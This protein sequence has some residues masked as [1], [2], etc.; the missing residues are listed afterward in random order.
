MHHGLSINQE[1]L[2]STSK[3]KTEDI[4]IEASIS[5]DNTFSYSVQIND[6]PLL[7]V[8]NLNYK[9]VAKVPHDIITLMFFKI[10][11]DQKMSLI[12]TLNDNSDRQTPDIVYE[13]EPY[14]W[15]VLEVKTTRRSDQ[16]NQRFYSA[17][18]IYKPAC[19]KRIKDK[20]I[21]LNALIIS[22]DQVCTNLP[23]SQ[24]EAD[25]LSTIYSLGNTIVNKFRGLGWS[26]QE[27]DLKFAVSDLKSSVSLLTIP[28]SSEDDLIIT[29]DKIKMWRNCDTTKAQIMM[30]QEFLK[31]YK[32]ASLDSDKNNFNNGLKLFEDLKE[33]LK[34]GRKDNKSVVQLPLFI[35]YDKFCEENS[36]L[37]HSLMFENDLMARLW[38]SS[39]IDRANNPERILEVSEDD[40]EKYAL[41]KEFEISK[42][43]KRT[44]FRV[45]VSLFES[46]WEELALH[47]IE[48]KK[49]KNNDDV[50]HKRAKDKEPFSIDCDVFDINSFIK[51]KSNFELQQC[52]NILTDRTIGLIEGAANSTCPLSIEFANHF[53]NTK[54]GLALSQMQFI[55]TEVNISRLQ[56][57]K[58]HQFV[59][60]YIKEINVYILIKPSRASEHIFFSLAI[61]PNSYKFG[62]PFKDFKTYGG[63][64]ISD[65]VSMDSN[66]LSHQIGTPERAC[67]LLA[68]W[69]H[70]FEMMPYHFWTTEN[71]DI[72]EHF[73]ASL[74]FYMED[75]ESTSTSLQNIRYAYMEMIKGPGRFLNPLKVLKKMSDRPKSRLLIW[76]MSRFCTTFLDMLQSPPSFGIKST[77]ELAEEVS[78]D[79]AH[80][81]LSWV[82]LRPIPKFEIALN[83]SY[84]GVLHNKEEGDKVTGF[85]KIFEKVIGEELQLRKSNLKFCG[86]E[87]PMPDHDY[88]SH[89]FSMS[90]VANMGR[91]CKEY[92]S[93][94]GDGSIQWVYD[95]VYEDLAKKDFLELATM[96]AS[97]Y[98]IDNDVI[99]SDKV[100]LN[101]RRRTAEAV[102][103]LLTEGF[104]ANVMLKIHEIEQKV[105]DKGGLQ[106]NLFKKMQ[107]GGT[108][109]I[110]VL[111][112]ES[113]ILV[114]F[115][116]SVC[117]SV[118]EELP[119]EM[120]TKGDQKILRNDAHFKS[121]NSLEG[122]YSTTVSSSDDATTWAQKFVMNAFA[123]YLCNIFD[124]DLMIPLACVLNHCTNKRLELPKELLDLFSTHPEIDSFSEN[125]N[126]LKNQFLGKSHYNDLL[127]RYM[128]SLKNRSNM[129]QGIFHYTS[130]LYHS[131]FLLTWSEFSSK[132][133]N[134]V[135]KNIHSNQ[136]SFVISTKVSSDDS[137][138]LISTRFN[139]YKHREKINRL[140]LSLTMLKGRLYKYF[141]CKQSEEKSTVGVFWTIEEF[142]SVWLMRNTILMPLIKFVVSSTQIHT[143]PKIETRMFIAS[144]LRS[145]ILENCGSILLSAIV[146]VCQARLHYVGLGA[147][148]NGLWRKYSAI[149]SSKPH[150]SAGYFVME[151]EMMC[152]LLGMDL[153]VYRTCRFNEKFKRIHTKLVRNMGVEFADEGNPASRIFLSHGHNQRY[154][155]FVKT[156]GLKSNTN[157][158]EEISNQVDILYRSPVNNSEAQLKLLVKCSDPE[159][160]QAFSFLNAAKTFCSSVYIIQEHCIHLVKSVRATGEIEHERISLLKWLDL[161]EED[162][163]NS[164]EDVMKIAFPS[165]QF[166]DS[167]LESLKLVDI[168]HLFSVQRKRRVF[169]SVA[170][171]K[172]STLTPMTLLDCMRRLWFGISVRGSEAALEATFQYYKEVYP[173]L[174]ADYN[175]TFNNSPFNSH[176]ALSK[177]ITSLNPRTKT[178]RVTTPSRSKSNTFETLFTMILLNQWPKHEIVQKGKMEGTTVN[179]VLDQMLYSVWLAKN[180]PPLKD[181]TY[182][183]NKIC[184]SFEDVVTNEPDI[185]QLMTQGMS[186]FNIMMLQSACLQPTM[187]LKLLQKYNKGIFGGF[188][189]RQI[190]D[191]EK[192]RYVGP[193]LFC[194]SIDSIKFSLEII[195]G[196]IVC[197]RTDNKPKIIEKIINLSHFVQDLGLCFNSNYGPSLNYLRITDQREGYWSKGSVLFLESEMIHYFE[198][199]TV[200]F[201]CDF[202]GRIRIKTVE[203]RPI[204]VLSFIPIVKHIQPV[205]EKEYH[206]DNEYIKVWMRNEKLSVDDALYLLNRSEEN[207]EFDTWKFNSFINKL[208]SEGFQ[209]ELR[210]KQAAEVKNEQQSDE[211]KSVSEGADSFFEYEL[212]MMSDDSSFFDEIETECKITETL[213]DLDVLNEDED[214]LT[215]LGFVFGSDDFVTKQPIKQKYEPNV[216]YHHNF[217]KGLI[218]YL[219]NEYGWINVQ[220]MCSQEIK[221]KHA[222]LYEIM[223]FIES[224]ITLF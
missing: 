81:L 120:L 39:L 183:I 9:D 74:L 159:L 151:P 25:L 154:Y 68:F 140:F 2:F 71:D 143:T 101:K 194:G 163:C 110:F 29:K 63:W 122:K 109:E 147:L 12:E 21:S 164:A 57:C 108:R 113:R 199:K 190:W 23:I 59:L 107:I 200:N 207:A 192:D 135:T 171:P 58:K 133:I 206:F 35:S 22:E 44:H 60:K 208:R 41:N 56:N 49:F 179:S 150:H 173:W 42:A 180:S 224:H 223:N 69:C 155:E 203:E 17:L 28:D 72:S 210:R 117:R 78:Q 52:R 212:G 157:I 67:S 193:G 202:S 80:G 221:K 105:A 129:M 195:D 84:F 166:Y 127:D 92:L 13:I 130:S 31:S 131:G 104:P 142:N 7:S 24:K 181:R 153:A 160:S 217:W 99:Y 152:G 137:S 182:M 189:R 222:E 185:V 36:E 136:N 55:L 73:L 218:D 178:I 156:L 144:T 169:I 188:V 77:E 191:P 82:T 177:F 26:M 128:C 46:D 76:A 40:Y 161:L 20:T 112:M 90:F 53:F 14:K 134:V 209:M 106:A 145:Q 30:K 88:Q 167:M 61:P 216:F 43:D 45:N 115:C 34:T 48:A 6:L 37:T 47:G 121:L 213:T 204:T 124:D 1:K 38:Y 10:N 16:M 100:S 89:E 116:E 4:R 33:T 83:L 65:F 174:S 215:D 168:H 201:T 170:I 176:I 184:K 54:I 18:E 93:S 141:C 219:I 96:K 196:N 95:K 103:D 197:L 19:E 119:N 138:V 27:D 94:K 165:Y 220:R 126:E 146:Q 8:A 98:D 97:A 211:E 111:T 51:D 175:E 87:E 91:K 172:Q 79:I 123:C 186:R 148:N 5:P 62:K 162:N 11:A 50:S 64:S 3:F 86:N 158:E 118:C 214:F 70:Q 205:P 102:H 114:H 75:K 149:I 198:H 32:L 139:N 66:R 187:T 125:I 15:F 85:L 132:V